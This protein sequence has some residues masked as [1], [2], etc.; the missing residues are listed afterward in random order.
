MIS[1]VDGTITR[2]II[3]VLYPQFP[4]HSSELD[5]HWFL[6]VLIL[7]HR[8]IVCHIVDAISSIQLVA[9]SI[10]DPL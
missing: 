9:F 10:I 6:F 4:Y 7:L 8:Q 5:S 1:D 3:S 2:Y